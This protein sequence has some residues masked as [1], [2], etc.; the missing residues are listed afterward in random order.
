MLIKLDK[1]TQCFRFNYKIIQDR[2]KCS[3][4]MAERADVCIHN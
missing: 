4:D 3:T 2:Y 1:N